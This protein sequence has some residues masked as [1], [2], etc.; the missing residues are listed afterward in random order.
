MNKK[1]VPGLIVAAIVLFGIFA[2]YS[3]SSSTST[4]SKSTSGQTKFAEEDALPNEQ[5]VTL[6]ANPLREFGISPDGNYLNVNYEINSQFL[7]DR[8]FS[9]GET[10]YVLLEKDWDGNYSMQEIV[11]EK[12]LSGI[13][14]K[15]NVTK[16]DIHRVKYLPDGPA[17]MMFINYGFEKVYLPGVGDMFIDHLIGKIAINETGEGRLLA[18]Y[19]NGEIVP[20][21][22]R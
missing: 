1:I 21:F 3:N 20:L 9:E 12:P 10:I 19:Q 5:V 11:L 7:N 8:N 16:L 14:L 6:M 2:A 22:R 4:N 15:G 18:L 13:F 17:D